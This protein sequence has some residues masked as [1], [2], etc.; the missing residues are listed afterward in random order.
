[1]LRSRRPAARAARS[2]TADPAPRGRGKEVAASSGCLGCH[3]IA[4]QGN[5]GPGP[6]LSKIGARLN[7]EEIARTLVDPKAPM[8]SYAGLRDEQP[9]QFDELVKFLASLR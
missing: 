9:R 4:E 6:E 5:P 8:P 1:V 2:R 3:R 7:R